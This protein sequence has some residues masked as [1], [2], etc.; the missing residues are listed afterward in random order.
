MLEEAG[1]SATEAKVYLALLE[2]GSSL[3]GEITK[4][5]EI[6]R[7]NA[8]DALERL[9]KK[10]LVTYV[11]SANRK[12]FE[13]LPPERLHELAKEKEERIKGLL[14]ELNLR[15]K[16][17]KAKEEATIFKGKKGIKSAYELLLKEKKEIL[18]YGAE[19]RFAD[20]LPAYYTEWHER[21]ARGGIAL[22]I[23][24]NEKVRERKIKEK[25]KSAKLKFLPAGY[26]FPSTILIS[27]EITITV[28]W[29]AM[30]FAFLIRSKDAVKSQI[31]FFELL[32]RTAK[33]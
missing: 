10:G 11:I 12:V 1:L 8:Y 4:K 14:P 24:F 5:A 28:V 13:P 17:S 33:K 2:L 9:S 31:N 30:P 27:G 16:E 21:R 7:T 26:D 22:K 20:M 23:M 19:S 32:W 29:T 6:N 3:A 18:V 15:F 25:L